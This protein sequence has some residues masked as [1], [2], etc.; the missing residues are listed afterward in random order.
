MKNIV[1]YL[2]AGCLIT[3][4][5]SSGQKPTI[6][7][8]PTSHQRIHPEAVVDTSHARDSLYK[9]V[10]HGNSSV[11]LSG[12][13]ETHGDIKKESRRR[14][15]QRDSIFQK[16][17]LKSK[18]AGNWSERFYLMMIYINPVKLF[19]HITALKI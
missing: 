19:I 14:W 8:L 7:L 6:E 4:F 2:I 16:K 15:F 10:P 3:F 9:I 11:A 12:D 5:E 18:Q 1:L 17:V 13:G